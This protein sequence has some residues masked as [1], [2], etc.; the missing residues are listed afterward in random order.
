[1]SLLRPP[2][3]PNIKF[4]YQDYLLTPEDKRYE[5]IEGELLMTPSP[6]KQHQ[7]FVGK[8]FNRLSEFVE[9]HA[10]GEVFV[11][12][13]DVYFSEY[14]VCQPDIVF[15]SNKRGTGKDERYIE[16]PPDLVVEVLSP[17]TRNRDLEIKRK[18][19]AKYGVPEY[20]IVDPDRQ[21]IQ[22]LVL[23]QDGFHEKGLFAPGTSLQSDVLPAFSLD[24]A[25]LF[26]G[27]QT[28]A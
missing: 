6:V 19:Y 20:W 10:L 17:S 2:P 22:V 8:L 15:V 26:A 9:K 3:N 23:H 27:K 4:T 24:P 21:T 7:R 12:P 1:M 28:P 13:M 14:D 16:G 25:E 11:S 18:L 5:L